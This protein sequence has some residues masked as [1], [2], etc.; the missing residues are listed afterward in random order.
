MM[1]ANEKAL[2]FDAIFSTQEW[3]GSVKLPPTAN[4][5]IVLLFIL[6]IEEQIKT[7]SDLFSLF[8]KGLTTELEAFVKECLEKAGL[9]QFHEKLKVLK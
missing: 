5:K 1:T 3:A 7:G 6:V 8:P 4:R 2:M 9:Q